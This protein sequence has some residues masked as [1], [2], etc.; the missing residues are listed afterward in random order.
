MA[1]TQTRG[2]HTSEFKFEATRQ[3][4]AGQAMR[5]ILGHSRVPTD[6]G[7][8]RPGGGRSKSREDVRR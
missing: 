1:S 8:Q 6:A 2:K 7:V 3:V 4:K 5:S